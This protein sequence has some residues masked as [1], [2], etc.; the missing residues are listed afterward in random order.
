M[1]NKPTEMI[2]LAETD[3]LAATGK[4]VMFARRP[5]EIGWADVL[6]EI[7]IDHEQSACCVSKGR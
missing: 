6:E 2:Y 7:I 1:G 4:F 3:F 5:K